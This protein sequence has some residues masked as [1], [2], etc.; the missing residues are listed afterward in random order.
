MNYL[1]KL[2][3]LTN[4]SVMAVIDN[5]A[6]NKNKHIKGTSQ[7]WF[8]AEKIKEREKNFKKF[9]KSRLYVD[10]DNNKEARNGIQ[11]LIRTKKK[12]YF[13]SKLIENIGKPK[14]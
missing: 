3:K 4:A 7:Y 8:D 14:E 2:T 13:E 11:K 6:P 1:T 12:A 10:K 5:V 9:K